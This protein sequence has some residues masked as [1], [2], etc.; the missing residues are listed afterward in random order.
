MTQKEGNASRMSL[1]MTASDCSPSLKHV[2]SAAPSPHSALS[3]PSTR[4]SVLSSGPQ[5]RRGDGGACNGV[6]AGD[7]TGGG[8]RGGLPPGEGRAVPDRAGGHVQGR[9]QVAVL[10][11]APA[12]R[13]GPCLQGP[14]HNRLWY[15]HPPVLRLLLLLHILILHGIIIARTPTN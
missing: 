14:P 9:A 11:Q 7:L 3:I 10:P 4:S 5:R 13:P 2:W 1:V 8:P 15:L 12:L 6:R